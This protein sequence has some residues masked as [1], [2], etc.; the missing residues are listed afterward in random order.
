MATEEKKSYPTMAVKNWFALRKRFKTSIP[1]EVTA[2]YLASA[3]GMSILSAQ[4]NILPYLRLTGLIDQDGKTTER[5]VKWRDDSQYQ[6]VCETIREEV[7]P[8][9]L[10][11]LAPPNNLDRNTVQTWFANNTGGG[12]SQAGKQAVFYMMLCDADLGKESD[13]VTPSVKPK[14]KKAKTSNK[15]AREK[16]EDKNN[17]SSHS[18]AALHILPPKKALGNSEIIPQFHFNI[19]IVLPENATQDTYDNIFKSI[20]THLLNRREE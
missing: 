14:A 3:V 19:Q 8:Q 5:A 13:V 6:K 11:D 17:G 15:S 4:K 16:V 9:E 2:N 18:K 1:K 10:L 7:Y 20:A 12:A